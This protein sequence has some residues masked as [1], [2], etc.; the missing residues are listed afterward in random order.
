MQ[1]AR[2]FMT[3]PSDIHYI[4]REDV[5]PIDEARHFFRCPT[6]GQIVDKRDLGQVIHHEESGHL[7]LPGLA[8]A[9]R[10]AGPLGS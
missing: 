9:P 2:G 5:E 7:P 6:C 8:A 1:E 10:G 4:G 3:K